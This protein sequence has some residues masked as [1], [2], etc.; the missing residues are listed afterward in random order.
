MLIEAICRYVM[1]IQTCLQMS[2]HREQILDGYAICHESD[3]ET[4]W[5][6]FYRVEARWGYV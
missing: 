2:N 3:I 6:S 1:Y 5:R 4:I